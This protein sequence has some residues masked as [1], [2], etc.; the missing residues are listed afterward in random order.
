[1]VK[2]IWFS[3][4]LKRIAIKF[5]VIKYMTIFNEWQM[6]LVYSHKSNSGFPCAWKIHKYWSSVR[7]H[8]EIHTL[9][10]TM[11]IGEGKKK[12]KYFTSCLQSLPSLNG[13]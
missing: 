1:M 13:C 8:S 6:H 7:K 9:T 2:A 11:I 12:Q 4:T 5:F 3:L 10:D